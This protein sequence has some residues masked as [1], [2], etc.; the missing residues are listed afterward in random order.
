[1]T[2]RKIVLVGGSGVV[3][4]QVAQILKRRQPLTDL[5][6]AGRRM[7]AAQAVA[8][9]VGGS[10][11]SMDVD[12]GS[13]PDA[14]DGSIIVA[15][16][17][18]PHDRL[19]KYALRRGLPYV[20]ITRWTGR[21]KQ[22]LVTVAAQ[23]PLRAPVIFASAWMASISGLLARDACR[24]LAVVDSISMDILF[25]V[26]DQAG[27]NSAAYMDRLSEPFY[28]IE[29]GEWVRRVGLLDGHMVEFYKAGNYKT[30]RFDTPDQANLPQL[31]GALTVDARIGFDDVKATTLLHLLV[32]SG[33]W[34]LLSR[35]MFDNVR[36]SILYNPG[37]GAAHRIRISAKGRDGAGKSATE[38]VHIIDPAG[39]THLTALGAVLQ[40]ENLLSAAPPAGSYLGEALL[41]P[42]YVSRQLQNEGVGIYQEAA[43]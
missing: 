37:P 8:T 34:S 3:G 42:A 1:M 2:P 33:I 35:P 25:A 6:I 41:D 16:T 24:D 14:L 29:E 11:L 43:K 20:D 32:R 10:A 17:N 21:V 12:A 36:R 9:T 13:L 23:G 27:P 22:A 15:M 4:A 30:Y 39:Q 5:V 7:E 19:L 18:D 28:T 31:T 26:A 40:V 38:S